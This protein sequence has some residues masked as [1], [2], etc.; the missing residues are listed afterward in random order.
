MQHSDDAVALFLCG[1]VM[2]G[3]GVDQIL[4]HP[5][6]PQLHEPYVGSAYEYV[7]L[8]ERVN[9]P[10]ER[11]AD[12]TY[13][14]GDAL[15]EFE[16][17]RPLVRIVNLETA[18]TTSEHACSGKGIHYRMHPLNLPCLTAAGIDCCVLANN[19]T[20][21]W[22]REGLEETLHA[23]HE[24]RVH[25]TGAG[26]SLAE[27]CAPARLEL[28]DR[29]RI[30]AF[31]YAAADSGVPAEWDA[32]EYRP[33][34]CVLND[35]SARTVEEIA[36]RIR[37]HRRSGDIVIVSLHW[38][39]NWGYEATLAQQGFAHALIDEAG[40][41]IVYGHSSHHPKPI[42]VHNGRLILYGCG[43]LLNDYEGIGG[44]ESYRP[45]LGLMYF[46]TV[47]Q[48]G[49]LA[50]LIMTPTRIRRLR[51]NRASPQDAH[52]LCET[53]TRQSRPFGAALSATRDNALAL[54]WG[55]QVQ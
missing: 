12:C 28:S 32:T 39:G 33:G 55:E 14:W 44:Y 3:R 5:A 42:E 7:E 9:G 38:G 11:P 25:T 1:D 24:A 20:L 21:D 19:H 26:M 36:A 18:V 46:P 48:T 27:A 45:E 52:W 13:I 40:V 47:R 8:A 31:A 17:R 37:S 29:R 41:D 51:I 34:L 30:L 10:I 2:M 53:L 23:L 35:L 4:P 49:E 22:G 43:D 50:Q 6:P 54:H 15:A 16:R